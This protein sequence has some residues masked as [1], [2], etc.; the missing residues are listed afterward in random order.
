MRGSGFGWDKCIADVVELAVPRLAWREWGRVCVVAC[1][2]AGSPVAPISV[3]LGA[4]YA[5]VCAGVR[6]FLVAPGLAQAQTVQQRHLNVDADGYA[7]SHDAAQPVVTVQP[8]S[9]EIDGDLVVYDTDRGTLLARSDGASVEVDVTIGDATYEIPVEAS[10]H[11]REAPRDGAEHWE[12]DLQTDGPVRV[13]DDVVEL[14]LDLEL[15]GTPGDGFDAQAEG[16]LRVYSR[17]DATRHH[18][19]TDG[20]AAFA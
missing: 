17:S 3:Q 15:D 10:G 5:G 6:L 4:H 11:A 13:G 8:A 19:R 7:A 2:R 12:I 1:G 14:D 9:V 18:L 16:E 20:S